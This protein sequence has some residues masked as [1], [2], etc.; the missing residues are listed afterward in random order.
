M[1]KTT[2]VSRNCTRV[3]ATKESTSLL[4]V[5]GF[6]KK[7][8]GNCQT[9]PQVAQARSMM[10]DRCYEY[11]YQESNILLNLQF[12]KVY[13]RTLSVFKIMPNF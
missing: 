6:E 12:I 13:M 3:L 5:K 1:T 11:N 8:L 4:V 2:I 7:K 10:G 9:E